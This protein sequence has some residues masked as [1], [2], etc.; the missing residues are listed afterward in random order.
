[1]QDRGNGSTLRSSRETS[2]FELIAVKALRQS[3]QSS[4]YSLAKQHC[5]LRQPVTADLHSPRVV[6]PAYIA[7]NENDSQV[8]K[9]LPIR[10]GGG[11]EMEV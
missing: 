11:P 6:Q 10:C 4:L 5:H 7:G 3:H 8:N 9:D 1:M 2:P